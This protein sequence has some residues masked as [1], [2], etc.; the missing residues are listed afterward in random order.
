M[1]NR[2][3]KFSSTLFLPLALSLVIFISGCISGPDLSSGPAYAQQ[4]NQNAY[5]IQDVQIT[6]LRVESVDIETSSG[7]VMVIAEIAGTPEKQRR[8][9]MFRSSLGEN[10]G[11]LFVFPDEQQRTFWMKD[12][13]IPL[14]MIFIDSSGT[15][16]DVKK[17]VQP[18]KADP[19]PTY[20]SKQAAQHVLEVNAG[21]SDKY[22]VEEGSV[23]TVPEL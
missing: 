7:T 18:C 9:L 12:T 15:I 3:E 10:E 23:V 22:G 2:T 1:K 20:T 6:A 17:S 14:D 21:F 16:V 11:M 4:G 5:E 8:G 19:C 13:L